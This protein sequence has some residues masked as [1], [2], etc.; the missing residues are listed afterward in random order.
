ML[1]SRKWRTLALGM[2]TV[3]ILCNVL[4]LKQM[5]DSPSRSMKAV[6]NPKDLHSEPHVSRDSTSRKLGFTNTTTSKVTKR[7]VYSIGAASERRS[8]S[9]ASQSS[10]AR[11]NSDTTAQGSSSQSESSEQLYMSHPRFGQQSLPS[12]SADGQATA[13][14]AAG[15]D[16]GTRAAAE[17]VGNIA[18][19]LR[20]NAS[21]ARPQ[22]LVQLSEAFRQQ[23]VLIQSDAGPSYVCMLMTPMARHS[24]GGV[25]LDAA[26]HACILCYTRTFVPSHVQALPWY[27]TAMRGLTYDIS[28]NSL[29][30]RCNL[31]TS[32][33]ELIHSPRAF[34]EAACVQEQLPAVVKATGNASEGKVATKPE[35]RDRAPRLEDAL[36]GKAP[37]LEDV[38]S[39]PHEGK[40]SVVILRLVRDCCRGALLQCLHR[41][42]DHMV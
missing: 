13:G 11:A 7:W 9:K 3:T 12:Q 20:G 4:V 36:H 41:S 17:E 6:K 22:N 18:S 27:E 2:L 39:L 37:V 38:S 42:T 35:Q 16:A 26:R 5:P 15:S 28:P 32:L 23:Q 19:S 10:G 8:N 29:M 34:T 24:T 30:R 33:Q 14:I 25:F 40:Q 1:F 31:C 21:E